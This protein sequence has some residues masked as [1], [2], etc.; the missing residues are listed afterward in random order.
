MVNPENTTKPPTGQE[1][2]DLQEQ[3]QEDLLESIQEFE[4]TTGLEVVSVSTERE[5]A[6]DAEKEHTVAVDV[7]VFAPPSGGAG[8]AEKD[9]DKRK[10]IL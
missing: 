9:E 6:A 2:A 1:A 4:D 7:D 3:L 10:T 8:V 5:R